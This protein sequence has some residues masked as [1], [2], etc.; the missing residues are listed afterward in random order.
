MKKIIITILVYC[1]LLFFSCNDK[2][3]YLNDFTDGKEI[4]YA[5]RAS[6]S[7][8]YAGKGRVAIEFSLGVDPNLNRSIIY[9]NLRQDSV[10]IDYERD[11]V[12]D[13]KIYTII[14]GI[15]EGTYSFEIVNKDVFGHTSVPIHLAAKSYGNIFRTSIY[16]RNIDS[17]KGVSG[18][19]YLPDEGAEDDIYLYLSAP[20]AT[21]TAV[22]IE[23]Q[24]LDGKNATVSIDTETYVAVLPKL[25]PDTELIYKTI[26]KPEPTAID[27]FSTAV[28]KIQVPTQNDLDESRAV[29]V[30]KPYAG[31]FVEGFDSEVSHQNW[32][33]LWDGHWGKTYGGGAP[34]WDY[35]WAGEAN[36]SDFSTK[37]SDAPTWMTF[38]MGQYGSLQKIWLQ[39]YW[40]FY[41][42]CPK[43]FEVW[44][45][46][47][48]GKPTAEVG[49]SNW[50][51][52]A[53]FDTSNL[54]DDQKIAL[55][56][57][58]YEATF[59]YKALPE[60][61]YYRVKNYENYGNWAEGNN[62]NKFKFD[63]AEIEFFIFK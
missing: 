1:S 15:N 9:W 7:I 3:D 21:S 40:P 2:I 54:N 52:I 46:L 25:K 63:L 48:E 29:A 24:T 32:H 16:N 58:G 53:S 10:V 27:T 26:H 23:Y 43:I 49:W 47:G 56:A 18:F 35:T 44:A 11:K 42:S 31:A 59:R 13:N 60:A 20:L 4:P 5:G 61:R 34:I 36:W 30:P 57:K 14:E 8:Y 22:E 33:H 37:D 45:Y 51:K 38:D 28:L 6:D 19:S 17:S 41:N 55:Y 62:A 50:T 39:S 12:K